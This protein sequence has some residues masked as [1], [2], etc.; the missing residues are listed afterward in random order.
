[1]THGSESLALSL[2]GPVAISANNNPLALPRSKKTRAL[3]AYLAVTGRPQRRERLCHLLWDV[4][5]DPRGALRWS[6]SRLRKVFAEHRDALHTTRDE[7]ELKSEALT[8]DV[9]ALHDAVRTGL[10]ALDVPTL[11]SLAALPRGS[12]LEEL[13]LPDILDFNAWCIAERERAREAHCALLTHL[14]A[15]L[16]DEP[17]RALPHARTHAQVDAFDV[18]AQLT[19]L[20]LLHETRKVAEAKQ[21]FDNVR[22]MFREVSA[23]G[24]F[25]LE[26]GFRDLQAARRSQGRSDEGSAPSSPPGDA[27]KTNVAPARALTVGLLPDVKRDNRPQDTWPFVGRRELLAELESAL[28]VTEGAEAPP[29]ALLSGE[30]GS[31]K[32]RLADRLASRAESAGMNVLRGRSFE[33]ES[34]RPYGPFV[35]ALGVDILAV[36][37]KHQ[38]TPESGS[39][40]EAL[41]AALTSSI[42]DAATASRGVLLIL[43]DVQWMDNDSAELLHY[44]ARHRAPCAILLLARGG[45]LGD[46]DGVSRTLRSLRRVHGVHE[47][48]L[49]PLS[50]TEVAELVKATFDGNPQDIHVAS[51]GN[52][53]YAIELA[54]AYASGSTQA[55]SSI[56]KLV[57]E[58][59][60][61]LPTPTADVLRWC[62]I[63]GHG[64][65]VAQLEALCSLELEALID[66]LERLEQH[67]FLRIDATRSHD[68]YTFSHDVVREAVYA[69]MSP[70]R[71]RL[72]H[73][74]VAQHLAPKTSDA[75]VATSIAHHASRA[76]EASLG[77][78]AC[79]VAGQRSLRV[80]ANGDAETLA[81]RG[82][83]LAEQI[84]GDER[85]T[86]TL[87]LL[88]IL[89]AA[90]TPDRDEAANR[91]RTLADE[92]LDRGLTHAARLGFQML[93]FLRWES[94][95][96]ADAHSNIMQAE[97]VSRSADP[98]ERTVALAQAAKCLVLLERNLNQAEAFVMEADALARREGQS[99]SAVSFATGMIAAHRG[100]EDDAEAAFVQAQMV[101]REHGERLAEFCAVEHQVMLYIDRQQHAKACKL[102]DALVELGA[103]VRPGAEAPA[104]RA[105]VALAQHCAK[106]IEA[107]ALDEA[108]EALRAADAK[109]ELAF[110]L[111]RA[112][113]FNLRQDRLAAAERYGEDALEV[114]HAIGR[115]SE[116]AMAHC[117]L[118][119]VAF[120]NDNAPRVE[121]HR[122]ALAQLKPTEL[123]TVAAK[124]LSESECDVRPV[125]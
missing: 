82:I 62:T 44:V 40:R 29:I 117:V 43:D 42:A 34:S 90:R 73:R 81:R 120:R 6:L 115:P 93:S 5:D 22:R 80:F 14:V 114:A 16:V 100:D 71:R 96:M 2:L 123:S 101:A 39:S 98:K 18:A 69:G 66:A 10:S 107:D 77:A 46:N 104:S 25:E 83:K 75:A 9:C 50:Q 106:Q 89:Y 78:R 65:D 60:E 85:I 45:E 51:A 23:P 68:R 56:Q 116:T 113:M 91:V 20:K 58:R 19:L 48:S 95:S 49:A 118:G 7:V 11:E 125:R 121:L 38:G 55:P 26:Q 105:L 8:I 41:F 70:P 30:P 67:A 74:K 87:D 94:S 110:I 13:E 108:I 86:L 1:M 92:A 72:M 122:T 102:G 59:V 31:G 53:L 28:D 37:E 61:Q 15:R 27:T 36:A 88:H 33:A 63:L 97:R 119:Q 111:T 21:T 76:G 24:L 99:S 54:R 32:T 84:E 103:R 79:V 47:S 35:D 12:F 124:F 17:M 4:T 3:L 109:Y 64:M 57:M 52:P 112:A